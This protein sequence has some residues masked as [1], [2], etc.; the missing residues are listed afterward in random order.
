MSR[1]RESVLP[2]V[3]R[4]TRMLRLVVPSV[5]VITTFTPACVVR[6]SPRNEPDLNGAVTGA[7]AD[8]SVE[9]ALPGANTEGEAAIKF[10]GRFAPVPEAPDSVLFDWSGSAIS[11]RF[12]GTSK[13]TVKLRLT[14]KVPQDQIFVFVVDNQPPTKRQITVKTDAQGKPTLEPLEEYP[15]V[16]LD[17]QKPHEL[18][19]YKATEA[20]KGTVIFKGIDLNGGKLL[21]PTRRPRRMEFIGDS[22]TCGYGNEGKNATCPFEVKVRDALDER[23]QPVLDPRGNPIVVTVPATQNQYLSFTALAARRLDAD[24]VTVC[25]SGKGVYKNYRE[26]YFPDPQTGKLVPE[27]DTFSTVPELWETRT[28]GSD[29]EGNKWDFAK[30][31]PEEVPQV[32]VV[33]LG[34]NDFAR[35]TLPRSTDPNVVAGDNIPDGDMNDPRERDRFFQKYVDFMKKVRQHRPNA[36]IFLTTS[37]MLTDRFPLFEARANL[38]NL[39]QAVVADREREGDRKIYQMELVEQGFRYGLGCD[40]HPNLTVHEIMAEQLVG[41]V[42]SKTCW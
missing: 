39:L 15:I 19:I 6:L 3:A 8:C 42:R 33:A 13:V 41:A 20:Q 27:A 40:Y 16:G 11:L 24:A 7:P 23:G 29:P 4:L 9:K 17:S 5:C 14:G 21:P 10:V 26:R 25:W 18:T 34:T 31:K 32:V 28:I 37:P 22:I 2:V 38:R 35:D 12:E 30:E 1:L 36:H